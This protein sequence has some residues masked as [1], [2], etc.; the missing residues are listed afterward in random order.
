MH[1]GA[2]ISTKSTTEETVEGGSWA[3]L[4]S[5]SENYLVQIVPSIFYAM[6]MAGTYNYLIS[7]LSCC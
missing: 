2:S 7:V 6:K 4:R 5:C 3:V 1:I